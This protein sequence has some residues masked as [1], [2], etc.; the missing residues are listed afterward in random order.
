MTR[1][2][3]TWAVGLRAVRRAA[4]VADYLVLRASTIADRAVLFP[5]DALAAAIDER[6][7]AATASL[8]M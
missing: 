8:P 2:V 7:R 3:S 4:F 1:I 5:G 6:F